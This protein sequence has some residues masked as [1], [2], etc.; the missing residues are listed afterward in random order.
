MVIWYNVWISCWPYT[1][2]DTAWI[3][4]QTASSQRQQ[5]PTLIYSIINKHRALW[6]TLTVHLFTSI[7][8]CQSSQTRLFFSINSILAAL[9]QLPACHAQNEQEACKL[10]AKKRYLNTWLR[11]E[12]SLA[13][14]KRRSLT[15]QTS[16]WK[17]WFAQCHLKVSII[18]VTAGTR[19]TA[20]YTHIEWLDR[21]TRTLV[22][23]AD[24]ITLVITRTDLC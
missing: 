9:R 16:H 17:Q 21:M 8:A 2:S 10:W 19:S 22:K 24:Q 12:Y 18:R 14:Q 20:Q 11:A 5:V 1:C 23:D 7:T 15:M 4:Q 6:G 13:L 3:T